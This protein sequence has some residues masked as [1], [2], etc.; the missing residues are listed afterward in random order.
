MLLASMTV[1]NGDEIMMSMKVL[2]FSKLIL[3]STRVRLLNFEVIK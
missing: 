1:G 3:K 2:N